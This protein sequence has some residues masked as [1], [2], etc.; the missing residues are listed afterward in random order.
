MKRIDINFIKSEMKKEKYT[1]IST[2]YRNAH[3]NLDII[4][5]KGHET[6]ICWM[7]FKRGSRCRE[8]SSSKKISYENVFDF[9]KKENYK[10]LTKKNC[11]KNSAQKLNT[12]CPNGHFCKVSL[13]SFKTG[14]RC[15]K[16]YLNSLSEKMKLSD[17]KISKELNKMGLMYISNGSYKKNTS[18]IKIKCDKGHEFGMTYAAIKRSKKCPI[19]RKKQKEEKRI[20]EQIEKLEKTCL[21][22][23][24]K[25]K[26]INKYKNAKSKLTF[27]CDKE[28]EFECNSNNF[29]NGKRC[30]HCNV[31]KNEEECRE[32]FERITGKKFKKC[33]PVFLT[34]KENGV[35]M[36]LDGYCEDLKLAFEYD[37]EQHFKPLD[38][39]GGKKKFQQITKNDKIKDGLCLKND[40]ILIR[41]PY[42]IKNKEEFIKNKVLEIE[43]QK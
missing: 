17:E 39:F 20:K 24:Y 4:C 29:K 28:H 35:R 10:L 8:C 22:I 18:S 26:D 31:Y 9:F 32:I 40:I 1:L 12:K 11:Y 43:Q 34:K 42:F 25:I 36:E 27:T 38:Y 7:S 3:Q 14:V 41:I 16:C 23:S 37:G 5:N 30:P 19:C 15:K 33:R 21:N 2:T 13:E 6:K